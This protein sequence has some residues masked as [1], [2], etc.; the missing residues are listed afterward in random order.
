MKK[1]KEFFR[2]L[3][4]SLKVYTQR[5]PLLFM[6]ITLLVYNLNLTCMSNSVSLIN[7]PGMGFILFVTTLFS[8]LS[9][10]S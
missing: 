3:I 5:I 1:V 7:T 8:M 2:K 4:V 10:I 9:V 6:V